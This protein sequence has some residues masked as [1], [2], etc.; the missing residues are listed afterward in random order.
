MVPEPSANS[1]EECKRICQRN[2]TCVGI[3]WRN[4]SLMCSA[5]HDAIE[6]RQRLNNTQYDLF[7]VDVRCPFPSEKHYYTCNNVTKVQPGDSPTTVCRKVA[8][9]SLSP[10]WTISLCNAGHH[11]LLS[12]LCHIFGQLVFIHVF[13]ITC[14][15]DLFFV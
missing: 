1:I 15:V 6:L 2:V 7:E 3:E 5:L 14:S 4:T 8:H 11:P 9:I 10:F 12:V 13:P